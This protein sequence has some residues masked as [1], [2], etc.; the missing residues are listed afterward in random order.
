MTGYPWDQI[1]ESKHKA[2]VE[3]Y[4]ARYNDTPR[5]G[6]LLGYMI[7]YMI[8]DTIERAGSVDTEA[9]TK[10]LEDAKFDTVIGP[11]SIR[12]L[13][14]QSTMGAWVGK[15]VRKGATGAMKDWQYLDGAKFLPPES[16]V[17]AARK[18]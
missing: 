13:D 16:E 15:L 2:F 12:G 6:S 10:A 9:M 11:V 5:L 4:R 3:A 7:V 1:P 14:N 8:R 17:K 18:D